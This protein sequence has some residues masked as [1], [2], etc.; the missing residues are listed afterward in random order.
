MKPIIRRASDTRSSWRQWDYL[1]KRALVRDLDDCRELVR[2]RTL[3]V[4]CGN[5]PY[6]EIFAERARP[7]VGVDPDPHGSKPDVAATALALPFGAKTFETVL[8]TQVLEHVVDPA[9]LVAEAERVLLPG[10]HLVLTAPQ[11]WPLHEEPDDYYRFTRYALEHLIA[12]SGLELVLLKAQG[13]AATLIGQALCNALQ[14]RRRWRRLIPIVNLL[15]SSLEHSWND[16]DREGGPRDP[17]NYLV[18][19][20]KPA[21]PHESTRIPPGV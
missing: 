18:V 3:D 13:G 20:R 1:A 19:A 8:A 11:Y 14:P 2:G 12:A 7:Y 9:R 15:F 5:K 10:G 6:L 21:V 16:A 17:L 4:G